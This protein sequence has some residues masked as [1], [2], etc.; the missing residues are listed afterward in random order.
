MKTPTDYGEEMQQDRMKVTTHSDKMFSEEEVRDVIG[1]DDEVAKYL[2][3]SETMATINMN[4]NDL[5]KEQRQK[6][7]GLKALKEEDD[8]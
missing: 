4:R 2:T 5:R 7:D 8:A 3:I 1:K 6:L